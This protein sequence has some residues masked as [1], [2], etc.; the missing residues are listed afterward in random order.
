M[1]PSAPRPVLAADRVLCFAHRGGAG[2]WPENT[3]LAFQ[4]ALQAGCDVLETDLRMTRDGELVVCHDATLDRTT[5]GVGRVEDLPYATLARLDAGY[6][7]TRDGET[8]PYRGQ[9]L[10]VPTLAEVMALGP[11]IRVN[12]DMKASSAAMVGRLLDF[13][14]MTGVHDRVVVACQ[15]DGPMKSFRTGA[16]G[17]IATSAT[18]NEVARF[19]LASRVGLTRRLTIEY[20]ALQIPPHTSLFEVLDARLVAAA[21]QRGIHVH[22]WTVDS[23]SEMRRF[24]DMGVDGIMSDRPDRLVLAVTQHANL[25]RAS[26]I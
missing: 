19:L 17:R 2:L 7:F 6:R 20:D 10:T 5:N 24:L 13:I 9:G 15:H 3:L 12:L 25:D 18:R 4:Q 14:E 26:R 1:V 8:Y 11:K 22:V 21:H 23:P 16:R